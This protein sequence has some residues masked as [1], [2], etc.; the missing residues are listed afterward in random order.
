MDTTTRTSR[1][2]AAEL[3]WPIPVLGAMCAVLAGTPPTSVLPA[4]SALTVLLVAMGNALRRRRGPRFVVAT[5][6]VAAVASATATF[7]HNG[8]GDRGLPTWLLVETIFLVCVLVQV[9][10]TAPRAHAVFAGGA[11][12]TVIVLAPLRLDLG[13][14]ASPWT[15]NV[16]AW[17]FCWG[18][19][20][21]S[22]IAIGLY[23]RSLDEAREE[24][25]RSARREQRMQLARDLHDWVAHEVTGLV[26]EAQAAL[27]PGNTEDAVGR[28]LVNIEAAGVRVLG[29]IDKALVWLR[30]DGIAADPPHDERLP[31]LADLRALVGRFG[32]LGSTEVRLEL[33][34]QISEVPAEVAGIAYRIVLEALT[35]V[36]RHAPRAREVSVDVHANGPHLIVRVTND[37]V[38]R[39][40]LLRRSQA[41][42]TGLRGLAEGVTALGGT[43]WAGPAGS[44]GWAVHAV[45]PVSS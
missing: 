32:T 8:T 10:R 28:A 6:S 27:I 41:G 15:V 26:L 38:R 21:A 16:G 33:D 3:G 17:C 23:L 13:A 24:S 11:V 45:L 5:A 40:G 44:A 18:L 4:A 7:G 2:W 31:T 9:V 30:S 29:S 37:G 22:G 25:V 36:R 1:R 35:N 43:V 39:P 19:L 12:V 34:D 20:A 14:R 42:G